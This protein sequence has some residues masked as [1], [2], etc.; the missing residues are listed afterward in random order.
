M[1]SVAAPFDGLSRLSRTMVIVTTITIVLLAVVSVAC[2]LI[3]EWTRSLLMVRLGQ[4]GATL[5]VTP[6]ARLAGALVAAVPVAVMLY[7]LLAARAW[8]RQCA[9][10]QIFT[11]RSAHYLRTFAITVLAQAPLGPI[12]TAALTAAM[13]FTNEPGRRMLV[14]GLSSYDVYALIVG[15][16]LFIVAKILREATRIADENASII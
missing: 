16:V 6:A 11:E 10:G 2:F 3:P 5:P 9:D 7:G 13:S 14:L 4:A 1:Q 8:F 15:S 12:T